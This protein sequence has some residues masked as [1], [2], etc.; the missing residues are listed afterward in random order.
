MPELDRLSWPKLALLL[1]I[2]AIL[3]PYVSKGF[4]ISQIPAIN[5]YILTHSVR[6]L[7]AAFFPLVNLL[8]LSA[9]AFAVLGGTR[10]YSFFSAFLVLAYTASA[11]LQGVAIS[12]RHGFGLC[13]S[14]LLLTLLAAYAWLD[15]M[16]SSR[17]ATKLMRFSPRTAVLL[18]IA[19]VAIWQPINATSL[20]PEFSPR[21]ILASG[22]MLTFCVSTIV[23]LSLLLI[24]YPDAGISTLRLTSAIGLLI[25][26][27]NL[28]LEIFFLAGYSW[29]GV[30]HVPLVALSLI[31]LWRPTSFGGWPQP[32]LSR[33]R[34]MESA[35]K[36]QACEIS[37]VEAWTL[38]SE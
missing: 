19:L 21:S 34:T 18:L 1:V 12:D 5:A 33:Q 2:L 7:A 27:G 13:T 32:D 3:P 22:S 8:G 23:G 38:S 25:G 30:L 4:S 17:M 15:E 20:L 37:E 28:W 36:S 16:R 6:H 11:F 26:I 35:G 14:T 31:G 9:Y 24:R 29:L 10:G